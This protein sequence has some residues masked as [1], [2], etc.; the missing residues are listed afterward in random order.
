MGG[1][2]GRQ[3]DYLR[4]LSAQ[5][6]Q[7]HHR[8]GASQGAKMVKKKKLA[9]NVETRVQSLGRED[10]LEKGMAT[11]SSILVQRIHRTKR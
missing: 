1:R 9:C 8:I 5:E 2:G 4:E 10:P 11:H 6:G 3:D 7:Q